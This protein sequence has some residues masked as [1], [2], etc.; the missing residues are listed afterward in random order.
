TVYLIDN[1]T[2]TVTNLS[3]G[4]YTFS[5]NKGTFHNRFILQFEGE[6]VL[7]SNDNALES[8]AMAPNPTTGRFTII[9]PNVPVDRVEVLDLRGRLIDQTEFDGVSAASLDISAMDSAV[10]FVRITTEEGVLTRRI[11]KR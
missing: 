10:Y 11:L 6:N 3:E 4:D 7:G 5:S 1:Y 8:I 9:S 2:N